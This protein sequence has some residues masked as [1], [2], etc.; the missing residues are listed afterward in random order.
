MEKTNNERVLDSLS[1]REKTIGKVSH[2]LGLNFYIV[3]DIIRNLLEEGLIEQK[4]IGSRIFWQK[5]LAGEE[6]NV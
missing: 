1:E 4:I 3:S 6:A 2:E 5:R